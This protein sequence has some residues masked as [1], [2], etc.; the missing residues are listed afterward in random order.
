ML[1]KMLPT[2]GGRANADDLAAM[3]G[4]YG[5]RTGP[6]IWVTESGLSDKAR[7]VIQEVRRADD[8]GLRSSDFT[9]PQ[10]TAAETSPEAAAEAEIKLTLTVLKYA[11]YARG[12]RIRD[13]SR[14]SK[15]LDHTPAIQPSPLVL[16]NL[17]ATDAPDA[18]LRTLHPK[19]EQ[20]ERL[21]QLLLKLR[22]A[23]GKEKR[24][25][26]W[27]DDKEK[28]IA[29]G[30]KLQG[31]V[32][33]LQRANSWDPDVNIESARADL[34]GQ[35]ALQGESVDST[36]DR[37]LINMERWRWVPS[38]LGEFYV[39][40]NVPEF[41]TRIVKG[42][43]VIHTDEIIVGQPSW[44]TP[45]FSADMKTIVFRPSWGVPDGIKTKELAPLLR[46]SSGGGLFGIFGG[47]YSAQAVLDA[48]DLRAYVGG[49]QID[50]NSVDWANVDIRR[51]S[52]QQPPGPKNVLG[53]V[54]FMFPNSHDVYMHDT[55][56]RSLFSKSYRALSHGCMR[57]HE[58]R[59]LA[60]VLLAEDKG[61]SAAKVQSMF[62]SGGEVALDKHIPVH[63][64]YFTARVDDNG[65]LQTYG[66]FYG[67]DSRVGVALFGRKVR[68]E[69]PRYDDE[70]VAS[71]QQD[72]TAPAS[73]SQYSGASTLADL[74][75]DI[76]SP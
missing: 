74:I 72:R 64:T 19:H 8:W 71:R 70:P 24:I 44:P 53:D 55:P 50:A 75:S 49:R 14:V 34:D 65:K 30:A 41:L 60:E 10:L 48:Y 25:A 56:E 43:K 29:Y 39:W 20:F 61:W 73:Q 46:K 66:D 15:V 45:R 23:K 18:Y 22:G 11:R 40:D 16:T 27:A 76:F 37:I 38:D 2:L 32:P 4:F 51:Y 42:N 26:P 21:R 36:I 68:F 3:T 67:L 1:R 54:K 12:G 59:R 6:L 33:Q 9:L 31:V 58:P 62:A 7:A 35:P 13:P 28:E 63:I 52:F 69:T 57:V 17:A 5:E 47:G